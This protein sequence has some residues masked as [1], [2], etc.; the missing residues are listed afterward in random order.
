MASKPARATRTGESS[1][2]TTNAFAS[3][4]K[5]ARSPPQKTTVPKGSHAGAVPTNKGEDSP[6]QNDPDTAYEGLILQK[7]PESLT[8]EGTKPT[9]EHTGEK[10][11]TGCGTDSTA[12]AEQLIHGALL[13][14]HEWFESACKATRSEVVL[15][16]ASIESL[17]IS[18]QNARDLLLKKAHP[19]QCEYETTDSRIGSIETDVKHIKET[20]EA[21]AATA[22]KTWAQ[23]TAAPAATQTAAEKTTPE[24]A[25]RE[26]EE[27]KHERRQKLK[28]L[29]EKTEVTLSFREPAANN[30]KADELR[31]MPEAAITE[32]LQKSIDEASVSDSQL[33]TIKLGVRKVSQWCIKIICSTP[34]DA[35]KLRTLDWEKLLGAKL[36][37]PVY[38]VVA[39]GVAKDYI[40]PM[41]DDP[42]STAKAIKKIEKL[43]SINIARV[44]PLMRKPRSLDAPTHSIIVFVEDP[45]HADQ[46]IARGMHAGKRHH[47]TEKYL[48]GCQLMQ[49]FKCQGFGHK[50]ERCTRPQR[51][52]KC[53][54]DHQTKACTE[55]DSEICALCDGN[56]HAWHEDCPKRQKSSG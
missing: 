26:L 22:H 31:A 45:N 53:A 55:Q 35:T 6:P 39:H 14:V 27:A 21:L 40:N 47:S 54:K 9:P 37:T 44:A 28:E 12:M 7:G 18:L 49:C 56:H 41:A 30:T 34:E 48:P 23:V 25:K 32:Y 36:A 1:K 20:I 29:R 50:A 2:G 17:G 3:S 19:T 13:Q 4:V 33:R 46:L 10:T 42:G 38:G 24:I 5:T 16:K 15:G 11:H 52:G 51:C 8:R 43:N